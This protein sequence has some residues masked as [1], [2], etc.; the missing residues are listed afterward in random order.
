MTSGEVVHELRVHQIEL[1]MQNEA[2]R[3]SQSSLEESRD[4]YAD[5][6]EFAPLGYL[7]LTKNAVIIQANLT[8]ATMFGIDRRKLIKSRFGQLVADEHR[9]RWNHYFA[10][11][12]RAADKR[13]CELK[14]KKQGGS[15]I[16]VRL[17]GIRMMPKDV[18][19]NIRM[20]ISDITDRVKAEENLAVKNRD[21]DELKA[22]YATITIDEEKLRQN[23]AK[24]KVALEEKEALLSEVHHRV[25][26]NLTAFLSLMSLDSGCE[27][28][29]DGKALRRNLQNR[30]RSMALIHDTLYRTGKFSHVD[31]DIYLH[32]LIGQIAGTYTKDS[33]IRTVVDVQSVALELDRATPAGLIIN[34]LVTNSFLYAF[35]PDFDC[36]AV[37][38]EPCTIRVSLVH[39]NGTD[40]LIVSDNGRGLPES[41]DPYTAKSLGL[42]LVNF[43]AHHQLRADIEVR[44]DRGIEF[45]FHLKN[46]GNNE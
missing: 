18:E 43:L 22:A 31:M 39:K 12:L 13:V 27:K 24:L 5:L 30:A 42:K 21:L 20:A 38:G 28:T 25:K 3:E 17:E 41:V 14:L 45:I 8:A 19:P 26:N 15:V 32:T 7:T 29:E 36:M 44:K 40:I 9:D 46:T 2:L 4:R 35:P 1:E 10:S 6:Y 33:K 37:R 16:I 23:E 11:I 34:E